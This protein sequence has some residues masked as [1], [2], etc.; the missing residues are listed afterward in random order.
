MSPYDTKKVKY[1]AGGTIYDAMYCLLEQRA[2]N[3]VQRS[4]GSAQPSIDHYPQTGITRIEA[5]TNRDCRTADEATTRKNRGE[6]YAGKREK[7]LDTIIQ[8]L[9]EIAFVW[10]FFALATHLYCHLN[11]C[12][13]K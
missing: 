11:I 9:A 5:S 6:F 3:A 4:A 2:S 7:I 1:R 8:P 12:A 10:K 13:I